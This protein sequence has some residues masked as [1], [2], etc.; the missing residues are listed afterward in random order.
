MRS[1]RARKFYLLFFLLGLLVAFLVYYYSVDGA[2]SMPQNWIVNAN[3]EE[4]ICLEAFHNSA[5]SNLGMNQTLY[6]SS[7][8]FVLIGMIFGWPY[9]LH[10]FSALQWINTSLWKRV[11]RMVLGLGIAFGV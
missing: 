2:W 3:Y 5:N 9:A 8:L 4:D 11:L 6:K 10:H 1:S 7:V